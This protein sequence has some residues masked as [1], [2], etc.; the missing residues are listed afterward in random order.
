MEVYECLKKFNK[1]KNIIIDL[2]IKIQYNKAI[3][4]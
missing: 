2:N 3:L 1:F 4:F